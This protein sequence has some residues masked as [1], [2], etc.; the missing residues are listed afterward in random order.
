[1]NLQQHNTA[2]GAH[3]RGSL[4]PHGNQMERS[5]GERRWE[6]REARERVYPYRLAQNNT[7]SNLAPFPLAMN[8]S[9]KSLIKLTHIQSNH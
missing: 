9:I 6:E 8:L 2:A 4:L 7:S 1:M 3:G 5:I